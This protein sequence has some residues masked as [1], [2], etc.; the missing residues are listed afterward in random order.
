[1]SV[2]VCVYVFTLSCIDYPKI[3]KKVN[4]NENVFW[5]FRFIKVS[6]DI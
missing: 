4:T 2:P 3:S 6:S 5:M 1:M